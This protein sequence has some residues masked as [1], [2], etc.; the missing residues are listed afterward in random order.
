MRSFEQQKGSGGGW[1]MR[2]LKEEQEK[3]GMAG[4]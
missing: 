4:V 2:V 3:G 1:Q